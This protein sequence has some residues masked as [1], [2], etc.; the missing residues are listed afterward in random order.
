MNVRVGH[1]IDMACDGWKWRWFA[2]RNA[3][4]CWISVPNWWPFDRYLTPSLSFSFPLLYALPVVRCEIITRSWYTLTHTHRCTA[5]LAILAGDCR[6]TRQM[7]KPVLRQLPATIWIVWVKAMRPPDRRSYMLRMHLASS[8]A[9]NHGGN[10]THPYG[11][12]IW[13]SDVISL[14]PFNQSLK[15]PA[16]RPYFQSHYYATHLCAVHEL[17]LYWNARWA[18]RA[19]VK[20]RALES[21]RWSVIGFSLSQYLNVFSAPNQIAIDD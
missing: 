18:N 17:I 9:L 3:R 8:S 1:S 5:D 10:I 15:T 16:H 21:H 20:T 2:V 11:I 14:P 7:A 19:W 13:I 12:C 6:I 4:C